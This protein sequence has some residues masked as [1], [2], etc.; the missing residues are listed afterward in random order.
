MVKAV[1]SMEFELPK[2][3]LQTKESTAFVTWTNTVL[4]HSL[5][6]YLAPLPR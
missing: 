1:L 2:W 6:P 4:R 3:Q 5:I